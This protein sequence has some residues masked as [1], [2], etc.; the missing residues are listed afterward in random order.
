V[1]RG[2]L[3]AEVF[4]GAPQRVMG[5]ARALRPAVTVE[6]ER[7]AF[8]GQALAPLFEFGRQITGTYGAEIGK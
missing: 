2:R 8:D 6:V 5:L 1:D 3:L 7:D 4:L